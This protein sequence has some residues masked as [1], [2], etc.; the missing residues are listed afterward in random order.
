MLAFFAFMLIS[1][2]TRPS[3]CQED[4]REKTSCMWPWAKQIGMPGNLK[5]LLE[6]TLHLNLERSSFSSLT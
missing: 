6:N 1:F 3:L 4:E 5:G 2:L